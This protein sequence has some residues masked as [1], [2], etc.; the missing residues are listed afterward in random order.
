[1]FEL[2][3]AVKVSW[4]FKN[5]NTG[6]LTPQ[7]FHFPQHHSVS[8][9]VITL[10]TY[11]ISW[12][13]Y[14]LENAWNFRNG[15]A[16]IYGKLQAEETVTVNGCHVLSLESTWSQPHAIPSF[17]AVFEKK[18]KEEVINIQTPFSHLPV[19]CQNGVPPGGKGE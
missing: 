16:G 7:P 6:L 1:M 2:A 13:F 12:G 15:F 8:L 18:K 11:K 9:W 4:D 5:P 17:Q 10:N 3:P 19:R 14:N